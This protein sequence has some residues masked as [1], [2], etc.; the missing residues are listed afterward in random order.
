MSAF[1]LQPV[2]KGQ[3]LYLR[4]LVPED[5]DGLFAVSSDPLIW[6]QHPEKTRYKNDVFERFFQGAMDSRGALTAIDSK[7]GEIIGT[8]R[9]N[10]L[11]LNQS[12]VEVGYTFL[13]RRCWGSG[14]NTEMKSLMLKHAFQFVDRVY[15]YIGENN[16]RSRRA[17]E[18]IGATLLDKIERQPLEGAKY[19]ATR[20]G[21][22]KESFLRSEV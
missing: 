11:D 6:E 13:A 7:T 3:L 12:C 14:Y 17:V 5:F 4:P 20:Y 2:L 10:A 16:L 1:N 18:K 22:E 21:L 8:S 15:F 9:F 19:F